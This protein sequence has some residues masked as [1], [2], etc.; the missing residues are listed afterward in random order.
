MVGCCPAGGVL[1]DFGA[2]LPAPYDLCCPE[3]DTCETQTFGGVTI[4]RCS[5]QGV[6][7]Q[8][9]S[10][11]AVTCEPGE[12]CTITV[13][14]IMNMDIETGCC[15]ADGVLCEIVGLSSV[16]LDLCCPAGDTCES[17]TIDGTTYT[18]CSSD[19]K[20][21]E[22]PSG[23]T[24]IC[25]ATETCAISDFGVSGTVE[26]GCCP[27]D[28]VLCDLGLS[29]PLD[30][31]C[32]A[33]DTCEI[34]VLDT[35]SIPRC[36][37]QGEVCFTGS[38]S[39]VER[40]ETGETCAILG[41]GTF[42]PGCCPAGSVLCDLG[43]TFPLGLDLCCPSGDTCETQTLGG[44]TIA[45]CSSQGEICPSISGGSNVTCDPGETCAITVLDIAD[46]DGIETGCC[47]ADSTL[48]PS[49]DGSSIPLDLC[50]PADSTCGTVTEGST[51]YPS[52]GS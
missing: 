50:C 32:P 18:I 28:G 46:L 7:C 6:F 25:E 36:S 17:Q 5:S 47:P 10:G 30:L 48:C 24:V 52:C 31:C 37:S 23:G 13:L 27:P 14:D 41:V 11:T 42:A 44:T 45:R 29:F 3:G 1:C 43:S 8:F 9:G 34:Q 39:G 20:T 16:P 12:T 35:A 33:G 26:P 15:P 40:C 51:S 49:P 22:L 4:P 2:T 21:C 38:G 19:K